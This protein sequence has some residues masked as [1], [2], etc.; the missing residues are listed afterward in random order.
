MTGV[1]TNDFEALSWRRH[2]PFTLWSIRQFLPSTVLRGIVYFHCCIIIIC[3]WTE[4]SKRLCS[5]PFLERIS[6]VAWRRMASHTETNQG[7]AWLPQSLSFM[8]NGNGQRTI[9]LHTHPYTCKYSHPSPFL[10]FLLQTPLFILP[11][12]HSFKN[13]FCT[14]DKSRETDGASQVALHELRI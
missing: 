8:E 10:G 12:I 2:H 9:C 13:C 5:H 6:G 1:K 4:G 14:C 11:A 3:F 7:R